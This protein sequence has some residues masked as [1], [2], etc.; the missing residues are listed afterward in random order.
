GHV[1]QRAVVVARVYRGMEILRQPG[2]RAHVGRP[3]DQGVLVGPVD[4]AQ[5]LHQASDVGTDPEIPYAAG[6][7]DDVGHSTPAR[8]RASNRR[9]GS[10]GS[11]PPPSAA[12]PRSLSRSRCWSAPLQSAVPPRAFPAPRI[13]AW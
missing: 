12:R 6:I 1:I 5:R 13:R 8:L 10:G 4:A 9:A 2:E 11:A 3:A 7:D